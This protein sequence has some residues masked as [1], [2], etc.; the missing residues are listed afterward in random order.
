MPRTSAIRLAFV[1]CMIT[2]AVNLQAPLYDALAARS[3]AGVGATSV[4]FACYVLGILPVLLGLSGLADRV[5]RK[6]LIVTALLL[7]LAATTLT[8][9]LPGLVALGIARFLMGI[10]TA[11]TSAVAPGYMGDFFTGEDTR[12]PANWVTASTA[13]GFGLGAALTSLFVLHT[14]SLTPPGLWLYLGAAWLAL[15]LVITLKDASPRRAQAKMLRLPAYPSG[16]FGYG[17]AILLAWA[18]VGLVIAILPATLAQHG[19]SGWAGFATFGV[20]SC[21]VL[22]QPWA[23]RLAARTATQVGLVILPLAYALI[24]WGALQGTLVAVLLGTVMASSACY[25]FIYLGGLSGVL[26]LAPQQPSRMSAGYF[27]M[28][29]LGFSVPV[30][31]TGVLVDAVGHDAALG[32]FGLALLAGVIATLGVIRRDGHANVYLREEKQP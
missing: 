6:P 10:G 14:P 2:T 1:L 25:G 31:A 8:L 11:L 9:L 13:L 28:A 20:C 7:C 17:L 30:I 16:A 5:G 27:L 15:M 19:L 12:R 29:Y 3:G 23:R 32:I 26:E 22:F 18:S 24:A 21:G 4:A